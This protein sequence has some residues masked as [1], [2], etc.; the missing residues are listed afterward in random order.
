MNSNKILFILL[1]FV[2]MNSVYAFE[3]IPSKSTIDQLCPRSTGLFTDVIISDKDSFYTVNVEGDGAKWSTAVPSGFILKAG[4]EKTIY[5]YVTPNIDVS[6]GNYFV[7]T[8]V[9][10]EDGTKKVSHSFMIKNCYLSDLS[11]KQNSRTSCPGD[12]G[13]LYELLLRNSGEY[14]ENYELDVKGDGVTLSNNVIALNPGESKTIYAYVDAGEHDEG[15]N[16]FNV[17][18]KTSSGNII[19][20]GGAVLNIN[21]CYDFDV[22]ADRNTFSI[23]DGE[24]DS[25]QLTVTNLGSTDN[26]YSLLLE[27]PEWVNVDKN[28]IELRKGSNGVVSLEMSPD[29]GV[30]GSF[31]IV[32]KTIP[33]YGYDVIEDSYSVDVK[34]CNNVD[35]DIVKID[36]TMCRDEKL[37]YD[38]VI[39]NNGMVAK[40]YDLSLNAPDWISLSDENVNLDATEKKTV[41]LNVDNASVGS[42]G[43]SVRADAVDG[44]VSSE[45][46]F[47]LNVKSLEEC[48]N[49]ELSMSDREVVYYD[50]SVSIPVTVK[51]L[52]SRTASYELSLSGEG[53]NFVQLNPSSLSVESDKAEVVSLYIAPSAQ[54]LGEYKIDVNVVADGTTILDS[55]TLSLKITNNKDEA[56]IK[57]GLV[58]R[59]LN[60]IKSYYNRIKSYYN[61]FVDRI[62]NKNVETPENLPL[63]ELINE[64]AVEIPE[65]PAEDVQEPI[66]SNVTIEE[67]PEVIDLKEAE[68][69][70]F[71]TIANKLMGVGDKVVF[72]IDNLEHSA[73]L[74]DLNSKGITLKFSSE[75]FDVELALGEAKIVDLDGD[76]IFDIKVTF[77][78]I[79]DGRADLTYEKIP[80]SQLSLVYNKIKENKMYVIAGAVLLILIILFIVLKI[81]RKIVDFFEE[82]IDEDIKEI[83]EEVKEKKRGKK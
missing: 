30:E 36:E 9:S 79:K 71:V 7:N 47:I 65:E 19:E 67:V 4:E 44:S 12:K 20:A 29:Y 18:A 55:K 21:P 64:S 66:V 69:L 16:Q 22:I 26:V 78:A 70:Q 8:V 63:E 82:D 5:T 80:K 3:L 35:V 50:D 73:E 76:G 27:A 23:C 52:G 17:V 37:G 58:K 42:Y 46:K 81:P 40:D 43:V 31:N 14:R 34:K 33:K 48:Y 2:L 11:F 45:D 13:I 25:A 74:T 32:V 60:R 24:K 72:R 83:K 1:F 59:F 61:G 28:S 56:T 77:N 49:A 41:L 54:V 51:N 10:T 38:A 62:R 75:P 6:S 53:V 15:V 68:S 39:Y 57:E